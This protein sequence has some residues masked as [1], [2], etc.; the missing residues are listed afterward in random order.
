MVF[1]VFVQ[2]GSNQ[3]QGQNRSSLKTGLKNITG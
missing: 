1:M 2:A 3:E